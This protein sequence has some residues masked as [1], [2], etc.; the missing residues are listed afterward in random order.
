MGQIALE[1]INDA[2]SLSGL[3]GS[4]L[5]SEVVGDYYR[6]WWA[7]TCGGQRVN[8][9]NPTA[10]VELDAATGEVFIKDTGETVL[11]SAGHAFNLKCTGEHTRELKIVLVEKDKACFDHLKNVVQRRWGYSYN[12]ASCKSQTAQFS[13]IYL[14]NLPLESAINEIKNISLGNA[15]FFFDPLR[16]IEYSAVE[17]VAINRITSY[18]K[19]GTEF[20][21]F[22][23]TSDW[24]LGRDDFTPLPQSLVPTEW[25]KRE[26]DT[27]LEADALF[28]ETSWRS[29]ILNNDPIPE[30]EERFIKLYANLLHKWFRY[31]LPLP[32]NP[33]GNQIFHLILCS[34]FATGIRATRSFYSEKTTNPKYSPDNGKAYQQFKVSHP[35]IFREIHGNQRPLTWKMLWRMITN[36]WDCIVDKMSSD[37]DD[38]SSDPDS[39][40]LVLRWLEQNG[41]LSQV[42]QE[43]AWGLKIEQYH[44]D[45]IGVKARLGIDPPPDLRPLA[46]RPISI[47]E[48]NE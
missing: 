28:G 18:Y 22:I 17:K 9:A 40:Q 25:S 13:N 44:L 29:T 33:K 4:K 26:T 46:L 12:Q 39:R 43:N 34:N 45:I 16:S 15:L 20:L 37:F 38:L 35:N 31:V 48:V 5:K 7:I 14:L 19:R 24:F 2:I 10:I 23:F 8:Y 1:F 11:G 6:F 27:I 21:I 32:F 36:P 47:Q 3:T 42:R 30:K 41:Y